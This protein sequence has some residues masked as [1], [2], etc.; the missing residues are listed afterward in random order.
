MRR[1]F[2]VSAIVLAGLL[3]LPIT[4]LGQHRIEVGA[5]AYTGLT[6][7]VQIS[8]AND[9]SVGGIVS[10]SGIRA[11]ADVRLVPALG[12]G[13]LVGGASLGGASLEGEPAGS[14]N[15]SLSRNLWQASATASWRPWPAAVV[16]P[17]LR[18][19]GGLAVARDEVA[20]ETVTQVGPA[21]GSTLGVEWTLGK[22]AVVTAE[23][24]VSVAHFGAKAGEFQTVTYPAQTGGGRVAVRAT[25][26][27]D[28]TLVTLGLGARWGW[29][30]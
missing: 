4:S 21:A 20:S 12:L 9:V 18:L 28:L 1:P 7:G 26:Y 13:V 15:R 14:G 22:H 19:E 25:A 3:V 6:S 23:I 5:T 8:T 11:T 10:A 30:Q 16:G 29:V 2:I 17:W 24:A 27:R